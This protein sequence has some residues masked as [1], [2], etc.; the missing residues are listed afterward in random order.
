M[1]AV[2]PKIVFLEWLRHDTERC[3]CF[4]LFVEF[5]AASFFIDWFTRRFSKSKPAKRAIVPVML[6]HW[7]GWVVA[8]VV[9]ATFGVLGYEYSQAVAAFR[10][11]QPPVAVAQATQERISRAMARPWFFCAYLVLLLALLFP[12]VRKIR[13]AGT[14]GVSRVCVSRP[15]VL[16]PILSEPICDGRSASTPDRDA[17][18]EHRLH[19]TGSAT[20]DCLV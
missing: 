18:H 17:L 16:F 12:L 20:A 19:T 9:L 11:A 10:S 14:E 6:K 15:H 5:Y 13:N 4:I 8:A 3:D 2:Q 7:S 1:G